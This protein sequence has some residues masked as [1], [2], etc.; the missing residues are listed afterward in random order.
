MCY[1]NYYTD[2]YVPIYSSYHYFCCNND[3]KHGTYYVKTCK[4]YVKYCIYKQVYYTNA[5]GHFWMLSVRLVWNVLKTCTHAILL[6]Y[7]ASTSHVHKLH[8]IYRCNRTCIPLMLALY[9]VCRARAYSSKQL[10]Y[11]P[12]ENRL[13][14]VRIHWELLSALQLIRVARILFV[15][16]AIARSGEL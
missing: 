16:V 8:D 1:N 14:M 5:G 13:K 4:N 2:H 6:L 12:Q 10:I 7:V 3:L 11:F 15:V 9:S